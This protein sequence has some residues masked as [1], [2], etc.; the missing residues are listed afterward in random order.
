MGSQFCHKEASHL[1]KF[2]LT[3][4]SSCISV[5]YYQNGSIRH[6]LV[7]QHPGE[8]HTHCLAQSVDEEINI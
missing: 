5:L 1:L 8:H 4:I 6:H 7:Q 2:P 3:E